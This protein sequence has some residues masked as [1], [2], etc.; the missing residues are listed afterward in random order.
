MT[1]PEEEIINKIDSYCKKNGY[2]VHKPD[3]DMLDD[4]M[5]VDV[6]TLEKFLEMLDK[7]F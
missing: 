5:E 4:E 2:H 7:E 1:K 6:I 3:S